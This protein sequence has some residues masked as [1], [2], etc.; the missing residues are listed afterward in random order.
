MFQRNLFGKSIFLERPEKEN[1]VFRA[2]NDEP[3]Y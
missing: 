3:P 2:V 1:M